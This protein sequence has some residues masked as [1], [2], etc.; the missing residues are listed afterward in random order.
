MDHINLK[1]QLE[2]NFFPISY[3]LK[4]VEHYLHKSEEDFHFI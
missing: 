2:K 1:F 3:E 4:I